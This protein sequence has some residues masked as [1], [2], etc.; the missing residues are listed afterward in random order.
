MEFGI[1]H[2]QRPIFTT[3]GEMTDADKLM[4]PKDFGIDPTDIRTRIRI[5]PEICTRFPE[6]RSLLVEAIDALVEV[7]AH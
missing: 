7:C 1:S 6:S 5:N 2:S 3:L 4:N